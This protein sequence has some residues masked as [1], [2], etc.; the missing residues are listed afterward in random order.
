MW[1]PQR[2]SEGEVQ[3]EVAPRSYSVES[4]GETIQRNRRNLIRLPQSE[5][6]ATPSEPGE[7]NDAEPGEQAQIE[8]SNT[9]NSNDSNR[10]TDMN[11]TAQQTVRR[12]G[13]HSRPVDRLD[14]SVTW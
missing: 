3:G 6:G 8:D 2:Q 5:S 14:P 11:S 9:N 13:Q 1:I 12:S 4:G 10:P 7:Q